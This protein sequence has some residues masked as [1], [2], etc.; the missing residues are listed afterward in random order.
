M[1]RPS[2]SGQSPGL[3]DSTR[4]KVTQQEQQGQYLH[5]GWSENEALTNDTVTQPS[6]P[7]PEKWQP[8]GLM[9]NGIPKCRV[10]ET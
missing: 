8:D 5:L 4:F 10:D 7:R 9:Q 6:P 2:S 1:T 3:E